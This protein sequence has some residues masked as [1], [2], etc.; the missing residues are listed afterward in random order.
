MTL[1]SGNVR[2]T[3]ASVTDLAG[4][5]LTAS[6]ERTPVDRLR[7]MRPGR[8]WRADGSANEWVQVDAPPGQSLIVSS[9]S[10]VNHNGRYDTGIEGPASSTVRI[11]IGDY[12]QVH[13]LWIPA[14]GL[15]D[16]FG[17]N[18]G[19][20]LDLDELADFDFLRHVELG[21]QYT[22]PSLRVTLNNPSNANPLQIGRLMAG[23]PYQPSRN[24]TT[25]WT[26]TRVDPSEVQP[27]DGGGVIGS[28]RVKY[29]RITIAIR[30][31][32]LQEA[33]TTADTMAARIGRTRPVLLTLFP[34]AAV[35]RQYRTTIYGLLESDFSVANNYP[36][37]GDVAELT[38][39]E[40]K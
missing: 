15:G 39:R 1:I 23:L 10:L 37:W 26:I 13:D 38:F 40:L 24:M 7:D 27:T 2:F 28:E 30:M 20:Y 35:T 9:V 33:L 5:V 11:Q 21:D 19:G 18:M 6:S 22:G 3:Y 34:N 29:R 8:V 32:R 12:D 25:G 16:N 14:Y 36:E 4:A 31:L 17:L